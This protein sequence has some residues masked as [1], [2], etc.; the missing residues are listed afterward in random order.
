MTYPPAPQTLKVRYKT[1][2]PVLFTVVGAVWTVV[3][4]LN[5]L[6]G[7]FAIGI[8]TGPLFLLVGILTFSNPY[9]SYEPATGTV[10]LHSPLGFK[11]ATY[12]AAK[13][14][15]LWFDGTNVLRILPDGRQKKVNL[16]IGRPEEVAQVVQAVGAAQQQAPQQ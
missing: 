15:R 5:L 12:G 6:V 16:K 10:Y 11:A 4:V 9:A 3:G 1:W 8:I 2:Y 7:A 14:E 13:G